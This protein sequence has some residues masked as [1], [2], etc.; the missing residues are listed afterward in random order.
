MRVGIDQARDRAVFRRELGFDAAPRLSVAGQHNRAADGNAHALQ[1]FII[2]GGAVV[3]VHDRPGDIAIDRVGVVYRK[4]LALLITC[5]IF[6][7]RRLFQC[8]FVGDRFQQFQGAFQRRR[9]E[10]VEDFDL[11]VEPPG[12]KL[13]QNPLGVVLIVGRAEVMRPCRQPP[14]VLAQAILL[15]YRPEFLLPFDFGRSGPLRIA[16][17]RRRSVRGLESEREEHQKRADLSHSH[18]VAD[19]RTRLEQ[20]RGPRKYGLDCALVCPGSIMIATSVML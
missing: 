7:Q 4:L 2:G 6:G 19:V 16:S 5:W 18:T 3:H 20:R 15:R 14:H 17:Q 13:R 1:L 8:R 10:R 11:R 9:E 12:F